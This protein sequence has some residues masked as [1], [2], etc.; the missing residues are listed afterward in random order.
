[1]SSMPD[2]EPVADNDK[3]SKWFDIRPHRCSRRTV[4]S[5]SPSGAMPS[6]EGTLAPLDEYSALVHSGAT[7]RIGLNLCLIALAHRQINR[8]SHFFT[9]HGRVP[10]G[11]L[12]PHGEYHLNCAFFS[13]LESTTQTTNRPVQPYLHSSRQKVPILYNGRPFPKNCP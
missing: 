7:W 6:H 5:Y 8:F 1:M 13:P 4:Q 3:W 9:A 11:T 2:M 10:S 12:A